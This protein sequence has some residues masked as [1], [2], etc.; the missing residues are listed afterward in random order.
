MEASRAGAVEAP[1]GNTACVQPR[2]TRASRGLGWLDLRGT[3]AAVSAQPGRQRF[4]RWLAF[5]F[6]ATCASR[7]STMYRRIDAVSVVVYGQHSD[8]AATKERDAGTDV[9]DRE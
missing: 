6:A 7:A 8:R 9:R 5:N 4:R 1:L 3:P 2:L